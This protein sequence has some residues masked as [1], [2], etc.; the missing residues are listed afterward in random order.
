MRLSSG[1]KA[2][3]RIGYIA[4]LYPVLAQAARVEG[5]V[6][7]EATI[8][9]SG[10][11]RDVHI[12]RSIRMLDQAAADA[13]QQWRYTPTRLNGLPVPVIITVTV[14]FRLQ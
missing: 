9:A 2:P 12:L 10:V 1:I 14:S 6:V 4:P 5:D 3:A 8:D 13:V 11:V 7:L